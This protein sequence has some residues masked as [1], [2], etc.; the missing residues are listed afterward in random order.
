M[1]RCWETKLS[2]FFQPCAIRQ[3]GR[4]R[5]LVVIFSFALAHVHHSKSSHPW[6]PHIWIN[7][8]VLFV[9]MSLTKSLPVVART[10]VLQRN[11]PEDWSVKDRTSCKENLHLGC[12]D[13]IVIMMQMEGAKYIITWGPTGAKGRPNRAGMGLGSLTLM[14]RSTV[15]LW[16][17]DGQPG[18]SPRKHHRQS[19]MTP[20]GQPIVKVGSKP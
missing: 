3:R 2:L 19:L 11:I 4:H 6:Y 17:N 14:I 18:S 1:S 20:L 15:W 10:E 7:Y 5:Y 12:E 13:D 8:G 9:F 16:S